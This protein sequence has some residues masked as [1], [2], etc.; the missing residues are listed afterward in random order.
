M[1]IPYMSNIAA[2]K[3]SLEGIMEM[4]IHGSHEVKSLQ[5]Y[6]AGIK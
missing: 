4:K 2:A 5:E 1:K 3:A 6:H